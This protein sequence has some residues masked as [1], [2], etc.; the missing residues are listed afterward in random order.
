MK[1]IKLWVTAV[2]LLATSL[3]VHARRGGHDRGFGE[4]KRVVL[5]MYDQKFRGNNIIA[6]KREIKDQYPR[7][8]LRKFSLKAVNLVAKTRRGHGTATLLVGQQA[9]RSKTV[10]GSRHEFH[11]NRPYTY[12]RVRLRNPSNSSQGRWQIELQG[13]FKVKKV[14]VVL[15]RKDSTQDLS[16]GF[17]GEKMRGNNIIALKRELKQQMP[18]IMPRDYEL[19]KVTLV[20]KSRRGMGQA[21][22]HVGQDS[23]LPET[24]HGNPSEFRSERPW[25]YD[26]IV[27]HNPS[28][29]SMGKWQIELQGAIKV[30]EVI[31]TVK[32]KNSFSWR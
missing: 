12:D 10:A 29:D 22:L 1:N 8:K 24:I 4:R 6:L 27:L 28:W 21:T 5:E 31:L 32:K 14:V 15:E 23:T 16:L 30:Y 20:A 19:V 3:S 11:S 9:S 17:F 7:M 2:A 25:T 18:G 13:A 26:S